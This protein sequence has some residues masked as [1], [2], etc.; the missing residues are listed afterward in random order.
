MFLRGDL[1]GNGGDKG[2]GVSEEYGDR[3]LLTDRLFQGDTYL[4]SDLAEIGLFPGDKCLNNLDLTDIGLLRGDVRFKDLDLMDIGLLGVGLFRGVRS[5][6]F[7]EIDL[8]GDLI[9]SIL[10]SSPAT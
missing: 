6:S 9:F 5:A 7:L 8:L 10:S 3:S 4:C 2:G 1:G